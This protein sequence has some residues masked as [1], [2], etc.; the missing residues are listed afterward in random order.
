MAFLA[1]RLRVGEKILLSTCLVGLLFL[2]VIWQYHVSLQRVLGGYQRL[3]RID[4][5]KETYADAIENHLLAARIAEREFLLHRSMVSVA[6]V[7]ERLR[8]LRE[9]A[10]RLAAVDSGSAATATRIDALAAEYRHLFDQVVAAWTEQGLDHDSGLQ[11]AFRDSVH[12]LEALAGNLKVD[13]LYLQL[14]Q[15]RRGEKDLGLRREEQYRD[16]VLNLLDRFDRLVDES[17]LSDP[18][19]RELR[20]E[21]AVYRAAFGDYAGRALAGA[22]IGGGKG[23]F[24]QSAHRIED[25]LRAHYV[26]D[27][28]RN[29]LQLRRREK[30][31]LLRHDKRYVEMALVE[32]QRVADQVR[33]SGID[34]RKKRQLQG[35]LDDYRRDFL[36]LVAQHDRID[37]LLAAMDPAAAE[38]ISLVQGTVEAANLDKRSQMQRIRKT[39]E[40]EARIRLWAV[41]GAALLGLVLA[42]AIARH[43]S[44]RVVRM[45]ALLDLLAREQPSEREPVTPG[46]R[47]ELSLMAES[48]NAMAD[49][50]AHLLDW[51]KRSMAESDAALAVARAD[52]QRAGGHD[53]R[54]VEALAE[55]TEARAERDADALSSYRAIN[56][57]AVGVLDAV[58]QLGA[59]PKRGDLGRLRKTIEGHAH[60]IGRRVGTLIGHH[61]R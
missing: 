34:A 6:E 60:A 57:H 25:L 10:A 30:D 61:Q 27:M 37:R 21:L 1:S 43:I 54:V 16:R 59:K 31:Y 28:E 38:V 5:A 2:A 32:W 14:M 13:R 58:A 42:V 51:W 26:P 33:E 15:V 9:S 36:A 52:A 23:P 46:G 50:K 12:R 17:T 20:R 45:A 3:E 11:G 47:N 7:G 44:R 29:I 8:R 55:L 40:H 53:A 39:T 22:D 18:V 24:R 4:E 19:K 35:L 56:R 49:H 41:L 48:V